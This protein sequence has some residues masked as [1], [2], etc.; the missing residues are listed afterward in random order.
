MVR[1]RDLL[2]E[3]YGLGV[4]EDVS[5]MI[6]AD[7]ELVMIHD[8]HVLCLYTRDALVRRIRELAASVYEEERQAAPL[9]LAASQEPIQACP[10]CGK[11]I[12]A[13]DKD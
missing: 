7:G 6:S 3:R 1:F 2:I 4:A 9:A 13:A 8:N 12:A 11:P 5:T 10:C